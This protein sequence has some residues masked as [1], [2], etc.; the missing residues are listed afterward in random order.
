RRDL[1]KGV[2]GH[3]RPGSAHP[4]GRLGLL[5]QRSEQAV[6]FGGVERLADHAGGSEENL[7][8]AAAGGLRRNR[9]RQRGGLPPG[10]AGEGIGVAGIY[11]QRARLTALEFGA[12]PIHR[13]RRAFGFGKD[14][15]DRSALVQQREQ[16]IG[17]ALV[18]DAR[19]GGREPDAR[20]HRHIGNAGR[21]ERRDG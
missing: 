11:H 3:D 12:A 20:D 18:T 5:R 8:G 9:G 15:G 19:G 21:G 4:I 2:G 14:A 13:R 16:H 6:E 17:A 10:L 7:I 1:R